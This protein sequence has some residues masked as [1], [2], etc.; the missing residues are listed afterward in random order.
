MK[1]K[2]ILPRKQI[3]IFIIWIMWKKLLALLSNN[4]L[5]SEL[6]PLSELTPVDGTQA[7]L[8]NKQEQVITQIEVSPDRQDW[9]EWGTLIGM[10]PSFNLLVIRI[11]SPLFLRPLLSSASKTMSSSL[12]CN[13]QIPAFLLGV[14]LSRGIVITY[15]LYISALSTMS[16]N[17]NTAFFQKFHF[18]P[19]SS[20]H[21]PSDILE[22]CP[23]FPSCHV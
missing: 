17:E 9:A 14:Q 18:F 20:G 2:S 21:T 7:Q 5:M 10:A 16:G 1:G 3:E 15:F 13:S 6:T 4:L 12:K 8:P 19:S 11:H 22:H 23:S